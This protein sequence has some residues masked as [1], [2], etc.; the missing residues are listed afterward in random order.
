M[1]ELVG[2]DDGADHL[3]QAVGDVQG[4]DGDHAAFAVVG[5][6][7]RLTVDHGRHAVA[8]LLLRPAEQPEEEP[9]DPFRPIQR[10]A[11]GLALVA[12]VADRDHVRREQLQQCVKVT[13]AD[14]FEEAAGHLVAL[15]AGGVEPGLAH[16]NVVPGPGGDLPA[17][18]LGLAGD[19]GD[20][21]E[22][23]GED[24]VE[25]ENG[26]FGRRQALQQDEERHG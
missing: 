18:R 15:L 26:A 10:L 9:G 25:Q 16:V 17:V 12:A 13:A 24:L 11:Q 7:A 3:D 19:L 1:L 23:V 2:V 6:S 5:D 4:E 8:A 21:P 20:L 22:V 14:G